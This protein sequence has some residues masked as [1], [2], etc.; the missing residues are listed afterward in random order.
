MN[1]MT[2]VEVIDA[3][4]RYT[5]SGIGYGLEGRVHHA[6]GKSVSIERAI[7]PYVIASDARLEGGKVV[8]DPTEG[9]LLVLAHKAGLDIEAT[10]EQLPR[11][12]DA[13]V[14]P[15]LQADG[16]V[17][18]RHG[19]ATG[20]TSSACYVKGAAPAVLERA[21]TALSGA[22]EHPLGRRPEAAGR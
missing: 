8:G 1:Q 11:A 3:T 2:A 16:D 17:Q 14:R 13:A 12:G 22:H 20:A 19:S 7:L 9:A 4:D 15:D 18:P 6:A 10:R 5:I 21:A